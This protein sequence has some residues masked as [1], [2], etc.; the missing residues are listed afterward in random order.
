MKLVNL[1]II[2]LLLTM[3]CTFAAEDIYPFKNNKDSARFNTLTNTLRCLVCQNQT[4]AESNSGLAS[5]LRLQIYQQVQ[6][7]KSDVTIIHYLVDRYGDFI[8]Y[9]P[10]FSP[11]TYVLWL[12]PIAFLSLGLGVLIRYIY[13][14]KRQ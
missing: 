9:Q 3:Q 12:A 1:L 4:L 13:K 6:A 7:G 11:A 2:F 5:D 10:A 8:L 14:A